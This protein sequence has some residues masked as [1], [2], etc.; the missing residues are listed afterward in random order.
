MDDQILVIYKK[1][2]ENHVEVTIKFLTN[3][4]VPYIDL[5]VRMGKYK[6]NK[7]ISIKEI[8]KL[9]TDAVLIAMDAAINELHNKISETVYI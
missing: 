1:A 3:T 7:M 5:E 4:V 6:V 8:E 9:E 2:E